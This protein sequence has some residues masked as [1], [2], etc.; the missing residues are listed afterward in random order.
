MP[1]NN[2]P[3]V[4]VVFGATGDLMTKKVVPSLHFLYKQKRLPK[5]FR[6]LG[7]SHHKFDDNDFRDHIFSILKEK[8]ITSSRKSAEKF[9]SMFHFQKGSFT[10]YRSYIKLAKHFGKVDNEWKTCSN[11]IFYLAVA[12]KFITPIA[13]NLRRSK[14]SDPCGGDEG[15]ARLIV[16]KPFGS[17]GKTARQLEQ[18]LASFKQEQIYRI[19]HYLGKEMVQGIMNFRFSNNLLEHAWNNKSIERIDMKLWEDIGAED[20]GPFYETVGALRDVGQNHMLE[21]VA[22]LTMDFPKTTDAASIRRA[23]TILLKQLHKPTLAEASV[24]SF[25]AQ[26]KGYTKIKGVNP[27]STVETFFAVKTEI[28]N[29]RWSG[30]PITIESGKRMGKAHK[31]IVVTFKHPSPC[32]CPAD[33]HTKN[34][35]VFSLH[36]DEGIRVEFIAKKPGFELAMEK[37][38]LDFMLY[39]KKE[40]RQYTEEYAKLINDCIGG[41]QTWFVGKEEVAAMW[42]F[43]DPIE[44]AWKKRLVPLHSYKKN[45]HTISEKAAKFLSHPKGK[46]K[47]EIGIVGLGRMGGGIAR[48]IMEKGWKVVGYNRSPDETDKLKSEGMKP[49]YSL[50]ELVFKLSTPR[51]IWL[52]I[53]AGK[54]VDD[55]L[56]GAEGIVQHMDKGDIIIDGGNSFYKNTIAR[57]K[58]L[59]KHGIHFLDAGVSG[60]PGGARNGA[61]VMI[62]GDKETFK[63]VEPLFFDMSQTNGYEFFEGVGAG[64][65]VKMVHN[66]IEY[67]MMQAIGEGFHIMKKAKFRL[68]LSRVADVYDNGSVIE[69][70]L[71]TWLREAFELYGEDLKAISGKVHHS[72]EGEWTVKTAHELGIRDKVIHEAFKFRLYSQKRPSY[73]GKIVSALRGRFGQHPVLKNK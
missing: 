24:Q 50:E 22:L 71:I 49:A 51:L 68:D 54:P 28:D 6:V 43:V 33:K 5:L 12:P 7:F 58:K 2:L 32:I 19:D 47:K 55:V 52:M 23:R 62:G 8:K 42:R 67:G 25:R 36:P 26:Y 44:K 73:A 9:L 46:I 61:C 13:S 11:K 20:R 16:E 31:E 41:D 37:R 65:F 3:T 48:H 40:K 1:V 10:E 53:P 64:H 57:Q 34:K 30:V 72:G 38:N 56:F 35:V 18:T 45:T 60:G 15:W 66:G 29:P 17:D 14:L 70:H 21:M 59:K 4:F 69:S 39:K 27:T 63:K